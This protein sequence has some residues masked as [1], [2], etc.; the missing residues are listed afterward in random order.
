M[1]NHAEMA[2]RFDP[3]RCVGY[4]A[5]AGIL[6]E[7]IGVDDW[8]YAVV[9][10]AALPSHLIGLAA[11]AAHTCPSGALHLQRIEPKDAAEV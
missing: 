8:G 6:P 11:Q 1:V 7:R 5:C 9:D 10:G 3:T 4:R 2:L